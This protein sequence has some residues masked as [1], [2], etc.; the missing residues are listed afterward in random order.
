MRRQTIQDARL[1][2][3]V[4][5]LVEGLH[6]RAIILFGSRAGGTDRPDSDYDLLVVSEQL[7]DYDEV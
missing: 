7:L 2:E 4:K 3:A 6:P 5:R 1:A